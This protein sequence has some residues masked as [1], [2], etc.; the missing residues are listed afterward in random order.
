[1]TGQNGMDHA[2]RLE[3][4]LER[5]ARAASHASRTPLREND[6]EPTPSARQAGEL[7]ARLDGLI[8]DLRAILGT[9]TPYRDAL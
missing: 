9:Q 4:A 5:I 6:M 3:A 8:A 1:M 7:A 2:A